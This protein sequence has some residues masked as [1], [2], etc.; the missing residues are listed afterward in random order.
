MNL[1]PVNTPGAGRA[2]R[3]ALLVAALA[4]VTPGW[5][6]AQDQRDQS[7]ASAESATVVLAPQFVAPEPSPAFD[8]SA[9]PAPQ[10]VTKQWWFWT[11]VG[12]VVVATATM[13]FLSNRKDGP[14]GTTLG[15]QEFTP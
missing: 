15:N 11:V 4:L 8:L 14:P 7:E 9:Q 12:T 6:R 2:G 13:L 1:A 5:S 10:P 3:V